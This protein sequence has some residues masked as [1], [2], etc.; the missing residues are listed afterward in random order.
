[1]NLNCE[2]RCSQCYFFLYL[3]LSL[4][5]FD[6]CWTHNTQDRACY[7]LWSSKWIICYFHVTTYKIPI[8]IFVLK[9]AENRHRKIFTSN[10]NRQEKMAQM[11]LLKSTKAGKKS[12]P[13]NIF[14]LTECCETSVIS[15][16]DN[17]SIPSCPNQ[18]NNSLRALPLDTSIRLF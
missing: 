10:V 2:P 13:P 18:L 7:T 16:S 15:S 17:I 11:D 1:M 5:P 4:F 14:P 3:S 6:Y 8:F 9:G 12:S